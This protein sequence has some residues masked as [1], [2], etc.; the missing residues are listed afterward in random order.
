MDLTM[1]L[2]A[3]LEL[4]PRTETSKKCF[5]QGVAKASPTTITN[6]HNGCKHAIQLPTVINSVEV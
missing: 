6:H 3:G 2:T 1:D 5:Q 4:L